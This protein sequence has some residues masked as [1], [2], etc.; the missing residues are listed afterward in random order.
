M[1]FIITIF[2]ISYLNIK[3]SYLKNEKEGV[4]GNSKL[5]K[6]YESNVKSDIKKKIQNS[7]E[8]DIGGQGYDI[9]EIK[10]S[11]EAT[12]EEEEAMED[13]EENDDDDD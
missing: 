11:K 1:Y 13:A 2:L 4:F 9:V 5:S 12:E 8:K 6:G 3:I 7:Y 10:D